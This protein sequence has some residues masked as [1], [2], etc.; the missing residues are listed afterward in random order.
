MDK[1]FLFS[2]LSKDNFIINLRYIEQINTCCN[3]KGK[4]YNLFTNFD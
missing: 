4:L 1:K 3:S 2:P